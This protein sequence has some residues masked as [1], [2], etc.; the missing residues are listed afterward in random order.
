MVEVAFQARRVEANLHAVTDDD[1][2]TREVVMMHQD[3]T[4]RRREEEVQGLRDISARRR[5]D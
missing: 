1:R 3:A 4:E 2:S 5:S